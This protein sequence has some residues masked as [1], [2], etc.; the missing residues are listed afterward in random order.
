MGLGLIRTPYIVAL[1]LLNLGA[2]G[3][4][5]LSW[6]QQ[7]QISLQLEELHQIIQ[8]HREQ[9]SGGGGDPHFPTGVPVEQKE[10]RPP[11]SPEVGWFSVRVSQFL[12][13]V[14]L[15]A[16]TLG[17]V[18]AVLLALGWAIAGLT[19]VPSGVS[20]GSIEI[21]QKQL[22]HRQLAELRLR[23]HGFAE[24]SGSRRV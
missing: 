7:R 19:R 1:T 22:A 13:P 12:G 15:L 23:R 10:A 20:E 5:G 17:L 14:S 16:L 4:W 21:S 3:G 9:V 18:L 2:L 11:N 24:P 6:W 8:A